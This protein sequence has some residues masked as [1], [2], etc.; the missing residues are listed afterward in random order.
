MDTSVLESS[1]Q[2]GYKETLGGTVTVEITIADGFVTLHTLVT[3]LP[4][5]CHRT[6]LPVTLV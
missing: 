2:E 3:V 6:A 5:P 1:L 4:F